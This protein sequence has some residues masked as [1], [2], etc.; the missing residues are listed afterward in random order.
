M[1]SLVLTVLPAQQANY[2][3]LSPNLME[4]EKIPSWFAQRLMGTGVA[5]QGDRALSGID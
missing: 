2:Y 4:G 1:T 5:A 3:G